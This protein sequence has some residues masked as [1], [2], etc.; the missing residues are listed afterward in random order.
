MKKRGISAVVASVLLILIIVAAIAVVWFFIMP[1]ITDSLRFEGFDHE[2]LIK[3]GGYTF[4][5]WGERSLSV[6]IVRKSENL[7]IDGLMFYFSYRGNT[8]SQ[9]VPVNLSQGEAEVFIFEFSDYK[10]IDDVRIA[11]I[12]RNRTSRTSN[13]VANLPKGSLMD[14]PYDYFIWDEFIQEVYDMDGLVSW[15]RMDYANSSVIEDFKGGNHGEIDPY[16]HSDYDGYWGGALRFEGARKGLNVS[17]DDSLDIADEITLAAWV[18]MQANGYYPKIIEKDINFDVIIPG[19]GKWESYALDLYEVGGSPRFVVGDNADNIIEA[20]DFNFNTGCGCGFDFNEWH[21]VVG[22]FDGNVATLYVDNN[23]IDVS[24]PAPPGFGP[25]V[26]S[27][28]PL[29]I[30]EGPVTHDDSFDGY[31]DE[32][33]IFNRSLSQAEISDLYDHMIE[34]Q[35]Y[36]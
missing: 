3:K 9:E 11:P 14:V 31:V 12:Y 13:I 26:N 20:V 34:F 32:V 35:G 33:M 30:G 17:D 16:A 18:N 7:D 15:W 21:W 23:I 22:T 29:Y 5:D 19:E 8:I 36:R 6:Q 28:D 4:F 24:D 10:D 27:D 2:F 1:F 25:M